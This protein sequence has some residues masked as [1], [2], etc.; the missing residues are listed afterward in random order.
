VV[1]LIPESSG[2]LPQ[3][4]AE[5]AKTPTYT[6]CDFHV[7]GVEFFTPEPYGYSSPNIKV[8]DHHAPDPRWER[9]ISS[10]ALA[11]D[12]IKLNAPANEAIL[13]HTDCD[14]VLSAGIVTGIIPPLPEFGAAAIAADHTGEENSIADL[15]Q[16][17][18]HER[19]FELSLHCL[20]CLLEDKPLPEIAKKSLIT[21]LNQ[22][23]RAIQISSQ[24]E[25]INDIACIVTDATID[26]VLL[27]NLLPTA[28]AIVIGLPLHEDRTKAEVKIRLGMAAT[29]GTSLQRLNIPTFLPGFGC[30]WNAGSNRRGGGSPLTPADA[31]RQTATHLST[32]I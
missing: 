28:K 17:I 8:V 6:I 31:A 15:L 7:L 13:N 12:Y 24:A 26:S 10:G 19:D 25:F 18:Q 21:R 4:V 11:L 32:L 3:F 29:P 30:R 27:V 1:T 14:S 2:P 9:F 5:H 23:N 20:N 22:R 16:E